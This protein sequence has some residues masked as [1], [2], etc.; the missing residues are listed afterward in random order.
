MSDDSKMLN[1]ALDDFAKSFAESPEIG[2]I[3]EKAKSG[4]IDEMTA[5]SELMNTVLSKPE[6]QEALMEQAMTSL[7]PV[8]PTSEELKAQKMYQPPSG[9]PKLDPMF[10]ARAAERL[11]FDLDAPELRDHTMLEGTTPAVPV[12]GATPNPVALGWSLKQASQDVLDEIKVLT[13]KVASDSTELIQHTDSTAML[14]QPEGYKPGQVPA[15]RPTEGPTGMQLMQLP[16]EEQQELA[17]GSY[18]TTQ[19]RRSAAPT[20]AN[21]IEGKLREKGYNS[22]SVGSHGGSM[23]ND[24]E[25]IVGKAVWVIGIGGSGPIST[26]QGF[27]LMEN[28]AAA[29]T[30]QF[31]EEGIPEENVTLEVC[32]VDTYERRQVGW[33]ALLRKW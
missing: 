27:S 10:E 14:T 12:L 21:M 3:I 20:L 30:L 6:L 33:A 13:E 19:G 16:K 17:W 26:N 4:E 5:M 22:V 32:T 28:A 2:A 11:Q 29:M 18:S 23:K 1:N 15:L 31:I 8:A 24:Q 9:L 25:G 7:A